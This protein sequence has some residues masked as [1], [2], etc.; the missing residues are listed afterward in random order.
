MAG[1]KHSS[2]PPSLS[3]ADLK[4]SRAGEDAGLHW[5]AG[6]AASS[7]VV[8]SCPPSWGDTR[9]LDCPQGR[10][11][12]F[13]PGSPRG[14]CAL[15]SFLS[16]AQPG[17]DHPASCTEIARSQQKKP[18]KVKKWLGVSLKLIHL[19]IHSNKL[20]LLLLHHPWA[21]AFT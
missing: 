16:E 4:S 13:I 19:G 20:R 7:S 6:T 9:Y 1:F 2:L 21:P 3:A 14:P 18:S 5:E 11:P 15:G 12:H 8:S 17:A 10:L